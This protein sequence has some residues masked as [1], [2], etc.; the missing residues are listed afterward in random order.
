MEKKYEYSYVGYII[1]IFLILT[2]FKGVDISQ[3]DNKAYLQNCIKVAG[4]V[5]KEQSNE[6][7]KDVLKCLN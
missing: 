3:L 5:I 4:N 1:V 2:N 6:I 7:L